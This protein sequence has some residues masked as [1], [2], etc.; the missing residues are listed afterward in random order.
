MGTMETPSPFSFLQG[1]LQNLI[2]PAVPVWAIEEVHRK[3]LL[4]LNH[5]LM[6]EPQAMQKL[7]PHNGRVVSAQWRS[8]TFAVKV[9]PA[10]LLD[11]ADEGSAADLTL[12][13]TEESPLAVAQHLVRGDRPPVRIEGDVQLA[14]DVNW[15]ADNLRWDVEEDLSR[16]LGDVPAHLLMDAARKLSAAL[17]SFVGRKAGTDAGA[18]SS[19]AA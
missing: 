13:L 19:T 14:A 5:V 18:G 1:L 4:A 2:P 15:L 11:L 10:G 7:R 12:V 8:F 3:C 17:G 16:L 6:Q 9:T